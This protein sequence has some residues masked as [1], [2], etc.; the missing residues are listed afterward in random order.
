M[1][2]KPGNLFHNNIFIQDKNGKEDGEDTEGKSNRVH[3][4]GKRRKGNIREGLKKV[5]RE[6]SWS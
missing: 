1:A 6:P 5:R 4:G 2:R 3:R